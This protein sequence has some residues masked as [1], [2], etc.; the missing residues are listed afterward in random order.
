MVLTN[1][2]FSH[3]EF[4]V[5]KNLAEQYPKHIK[6]NII[7]QRLMDKLE[8]HTIEILLRNAIFYGL[9]DVEDKKK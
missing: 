4:V 2:N 7:I 9:T 5:L 1:I 6:R 8:A 3:D